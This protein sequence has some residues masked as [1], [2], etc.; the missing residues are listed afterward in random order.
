[1]EWHQLVGGAHPP[2]PGQGAQLNAVSCVSA[3][4]CTA[5]GHFYGVAGVPKTLVESWNGTSWSVVPIPHLSSSSYLFGVSCVSAAACTAVGS[6]EN[7]RKAQRVLAESWN[8]TSWSVVPSPNAGRV[9]SANVLAGVSCVSATACTAAGG[10]YDWGSN[11][12]KTLVESWDGT[13][14]SVVPTPNAG[15]PTS[16]DLLNGVSCVSAAACAAAGYFYGSH[17]PEKTLIE[18]SS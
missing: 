4:T 8:G 18:S 15:L 5:V 16:F 3:A 9:N 2:T 6:H 14:W 17:S 7:T 10:Y 1:M 12:E 13:S 11:N